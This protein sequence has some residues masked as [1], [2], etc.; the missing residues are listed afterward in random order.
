MGVAAGVTIYCGLAALRG[1]LT[2]AAP[3]HAASRMTGVGLVDAKTGAKKASK[4]HLRFQIRTVHMG[5]GVF[6]F[7]WTAA[8]RS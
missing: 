1:R 5:P 8:A 6:T 3:G 2:V 4:L 7:C